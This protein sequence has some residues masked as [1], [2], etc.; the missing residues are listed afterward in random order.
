MYT[1]TGSDYPGHLLPTDKGRWGS[2]NGK[3]F[4][5]TFDEVA[6]ELPANWEVINPW[7]TVITRGDIG[8]WQ[9]GFEFSSAAWHDS[10]SVGSE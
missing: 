1:Y 10:Q 7:S 9:Y 3:T 5:K 2:E 8:G 4:G 6:Q